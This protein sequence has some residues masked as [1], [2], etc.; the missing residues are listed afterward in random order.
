[1]TLQAWLHSP[2]A[3]AAMIKGTN[4]PA[5][6]L[7]YSFVHGNLVYHRDKGSW[8]VPPPAER[9]LIIEK[10]HHELNHVGGDRLKAYL[11]REYWWPGLAN[12]VAAFQ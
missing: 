6:W 7:Q 3:K 4:D 8:V 2:A 10:V 11:T 1:M 9:E 12:D 5:E